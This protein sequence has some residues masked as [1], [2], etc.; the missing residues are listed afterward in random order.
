MPNLTCKLKM[1]FRLI[2]AL[3]ILLYKLPTYASTKRALLVGI[4]TYPSYKTP[5]MSWGKIHGTNDISLLSKTLRKQGFSITTLKN[6]HA[7][8][9]A[10]RKALN[11]LY[12][13]TR[14]GDLIYIH[15]SCHGQPFED[16][17]GDEKDGWDES[18][19]PYDAGA[20][21]LPNVY[22]GN[23]H[24]TDDELNIFINKIRHKAGSCGYVYVVI[25]AC[26]AGDSSRGNDV[27]YVRGSKKGFSKHKKIY[28]PRINRNSVMRIVEGKNMSGTC[29]IEACRAYQSNCEIKQ[30]ETYYGPLSYYINKVLQRVNLS[31]S[32]EWTNRVRQYMSADKRLIRQ[33]MVIEKTNK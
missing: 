28:A 18:I 9:S 26:H 29:Y 7:K 24:I 10:I 8:A 30:G 17:S 27:D 22:E 6:N 20:I 4:S 15:F 2:L 19:V 32:V 23:K 12:N 31:N 14:Q 5:E 3:T 25:D 21:Y 1:T 13:D 16:L 11:K 33:N